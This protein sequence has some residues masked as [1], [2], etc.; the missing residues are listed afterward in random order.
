[1]YKC[2]TEF[3]DDNDKT[4]QYG[5]IISE[6]EYNDLTSQQQRKYEVVGTLSVVG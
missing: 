5:D 6:E 2:K 3:I 4:H 1:M